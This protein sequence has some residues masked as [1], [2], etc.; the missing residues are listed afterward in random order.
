MEKKIWSHFFIWFF[1]ENN[2]R[3]DI[4]YTSKEAIVAGRIFR[5]FRDLTEKL[6][7]E[8]INANW[9]VEVNAVTKQYNN[10]KQSSAKLTPFEVFMK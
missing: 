4:R 10:T 3:R 6:V 5:T 8:K 1:D 2:T 9:I 7:F